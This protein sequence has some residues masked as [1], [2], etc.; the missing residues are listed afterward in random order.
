[1]DMGQLE[2]I[3]DSY[4]FTWLSLIFAYFWIGLQKCKLLMLSESFCDYTY[5]IYENVFYENIFG[6]PQFDKRFVP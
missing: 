5:Y 4:F 2:A 6:S 3:L 1:M